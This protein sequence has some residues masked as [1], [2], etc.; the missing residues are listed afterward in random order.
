MY[1]SLCKE[2]N[3]QIVV[4]ETFSRGAIDLSPI[5][6]KVKAANPDALFVAPYLPDALLLIR[7]MRELDLNVK[8]NFCPAVGYS[9]IDFWKKSGGDGE[10]CLDGVTWDASTNTTISKRFV[11][12][13]KARYGYSPDMHG[14]WGYTDM[15]VIA[16]ALERARSTE[17]GAILKALKETDIELPL[18]RIKFGP[19]NQN[20][21]VWGVVIQ[22]QNGE[23]KVVYPPDKKVADIIYPIP[24]W[25]ER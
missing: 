25:A 6:L 7:Q 15:Y 11:E 24:K 5:I 9:D 13:F 10:Y 8:Y 17:P 23:M 18:G 21:E 20:H 4:D 19:D 16:D 1:L 14:E 12:A 2:F 22:W 3:I